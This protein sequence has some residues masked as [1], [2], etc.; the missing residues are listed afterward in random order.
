MTT[1]D[2]ITVARRFLQDTQS[3]Y[4]W[5]NFELKSGLE[6]GIAKLN[7]LRPETRYVNGVLT[8]G[9]QLPDDNDTSISIDSRFLEPLVYYVVYTAYAQDNTDTVNQQLAENSLA[10]FMS[11]IQQ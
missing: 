6:L 9:I 8:D 4:R 11:F 2:I 3:P 1:N 10:K 7:S 5:E